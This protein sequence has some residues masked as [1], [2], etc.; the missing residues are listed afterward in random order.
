M[1]QSQHTESALKTDQNKRSKQQANHTDGQAGF[2]AEALSVF[3]APPMALPAV[4]SPRRQ[5]TLQM[6]QN[7]VLRMQQTHGNA[8][9]CRMLA[10]QRNSVQRD[11][12]D[13][14]AQSASST[15]A[16]QT[17][18]QTGPGQQA[19]AQ[20]QGQP[21]QSGP[22]DDETQ[23]LM[24]GHAGA[25]GSVQRDA[26]GAGRGEQDKPLYIFPIIL[27]GP[28]YKPDAEFRLAAAWATNAQSG[29]IIQEVLNKQ[30][31]A[32][33]EDGTPGSM[34]EQYYEAWNVGPGSLGVVTPA[35]DNVND[36]FDRPAITPIAHRSTT[37]YWIKTGKV[38][39]VSALDPAAGFAAGNVKSARDLLSTTNRPNNLGSVLNNRKYGGHWDSCD[40]KKPTHDP[41]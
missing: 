40:P 4:G 20:G 22:I 14:N 16:S 21:G 37:G 6:R 24:L 2:E 33:C 17:N 5:G 18:T 13:P 35:V 8:A 1:P 36:I 26:G 32:S 3:S 31:F 38:Y 7:T 34:A 23:Q 25:A 19:N 11:D 28:T 12:D 29:F 30:N 15:S 10:A 9:V 27:E 39:W 41:T